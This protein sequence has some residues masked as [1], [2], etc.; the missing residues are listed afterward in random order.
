MRRGGEMGR[1][2]GEMGRR[3]GEMGRSGGEGGGVGERGR[4]AWG[5]RGRRGKGKGEERGKDGEWERREGV[6]RTGNDRKKVR[7][8][9]TVHIECKKNHL[10]TCSSIPCV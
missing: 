2:G 8:V 3:G 7:G 10:H 6:G 4:E 1:R 5:K 9:V